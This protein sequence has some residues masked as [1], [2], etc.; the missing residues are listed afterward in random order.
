[1]SD[2]DMW[3]LVVGFVLPLVLSVIIQTGWSPRLQ[4]ILAFVVAAI[5]AAVTL[6]L[7]NDLTGRSWV[8]AT[9]VILVTA[10]ATYHGFWKPTNVA[11]SIESRT[12]IGGG[13]PPAE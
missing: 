8:S 13:A 7:K 2:L 5:V 4:A 10:I 12:N 9:L 1:M 3:T 6:Y 11:N